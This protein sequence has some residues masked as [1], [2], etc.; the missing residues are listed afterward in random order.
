MLEVKLLGKFEIRLNGETIDISS[1]PAQTLLAYL[2]LNAPNSYRRENLAGLL[3]PDSNETNARNNLRQAL[4]RLRKSVGEEFFLADKVSVGFNPQSEY[5]LD[6]DLLQAGI[7]D[8]T[9]VDTLMQ[10][11]AAYAD[12]LLPGFYDDWVMLEQE[13]LQALYED[14]MQMLLERLIEAGRWRETREWA[15]RWIA[16]GLTPEPAYRALMTAQAGL[17]D[18]AS[19]AAVFQRCAEALDEEFSVEPSAETQTLLQKLTSG[20]IPLHSQ[21]HGATTRQVKLPI[22]PTPFVGR[23]DELSRLTA[24]LDDPTVKLV[25]LLGPGGIGKTRLAI[26]AARAQAKTFTDGVYFVSLVSIDDPGFISSQ[27]AEAL[28]LPFYVRDQREHW[29]YDTQIEQLLAYLKEK[30][31]LLVLDNTEHLLSAAFSCLPKWEKGVDQLVAGIIQTAPGVKILATSRERLNLHG[32]T[33]VP[34][35]GLDVPEPEANKQKGA[36]SPDNGQDLAAYSAVELFRESARRVSA[37]FEVRPDNV[38]DVIDICHLVGGMPLGIELAATWSELLSPAEI[39]AEIRQGLDFLE[40]D[41]HNIPDRQRSIRLVFESAWKRLTPTEQQVFQQLSIFRGGFTREAAQ[42]VAGAS[43]RTLMALVNKSLLRPE[44]TGRYRLH[45]LLRQFGTERLA[46]DPATETAVRDRHCAYFAAFLQRKEVNLQGQ[47]QGQT[48]AEI[49]VEVDNARTA[50]QWAV[51][52]G[53][54]D[55]IDRAM[56]SLCEYHRIRGRID[57]GW[58][59]FDQAAMVLGW[60]GFGA[61]EDIP[62]SDTMFDEMMQ[63]LDIPSVREE[64]GDERQKLLGKLLARYNR[65]YCESPGRAWKACQTRQETLQLLSQVGLRREMAWLLRYMAHVW[66]TPWQTKA[67]YQQALAIFE[68]VGDEQGEVETLYRLGWAATQLGDYQEAKQLF[69]NSLARAK[70]LDRQ[71]ITLFC[72]YE[73][74]YIQWVFGDSQTAQDY[75]R[76]SIAIATEIGY[77]NVIAY[78]QRYL[79]RIAMSQ[80]DLQMA[81]EYLQ[82]SLAIYE[83]LG[84]RGMKAEALAELGHVAVNAGDFTTAGQLARDSLALCRELEYRAGQIEPYTVLGEVALALDN[85]PESETYFQKALQTAIE[86]WVPSYALHALAGTARLLAAKGEKEKALEL[87]TFMIHHPASWKWSKDS[88]ASLISDLETELPSNMVKAAQTWGEEKKLEGVTEELTTAVV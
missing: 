18:Q 38:A 81:E 39:A 9:S 74:G 66:Q 19:V 26:E 80:G 15:E 10:T 58:R 40:T 62:D 50:W 36:S 82:D 21:K 2:I 42:T 11:V 48:L 45:E 86:V 20:E 51:A 71:D 68:E 87:A 3:W 53:K 1:R 76:E 35:D 65:F 64:N 28:D 57:E 29:E 52:Q 8:R 60:G 12:K 27:I 24:L 30:Q 73:L 84:L 33:L 49:E 63:W 79:A 43:L 32:E 47:Q 4:W 61:V 22:Q 34:V 54:L 67:L 69:Q 16:Q 55:E 41:L 7:N 46:Q 75:C 14:R 44:L 88:I 70:K 59:F 23:A 37:N 72:L 78:A 77:P 5:Q 17:G 25:T 6:A 85:F 13:R 31:L 83:E 56:E